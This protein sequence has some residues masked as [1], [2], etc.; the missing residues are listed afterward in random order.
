MIENGRHGLSMTG[1]EA[2]YLPTGGSSV[3]QLGHVQWHET[4]TH[5]RVVGNRQFSLRGAERA[6][7][8]RLQL[9]NGCSHDAAHG[10]TGVWAGSPNSAD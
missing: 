4:T 2:H 5:R 6:A 10:S 9:R 7:L 1:A 8:P 3:G